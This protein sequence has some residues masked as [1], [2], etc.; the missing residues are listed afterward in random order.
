M[1][2]S[3]LD[4]IH[5]DLLHDSV[6]FLRTWNI[7]SFSIL[8]SGVSGWRLDQIW[9]QEE[10]V[11]RKQEDLHPRIAAVNWNREIIKQ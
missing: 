1:S 3:L 5:H 8:I 2:L 6:I 9:T 4:L 10:N 7:I 11:V